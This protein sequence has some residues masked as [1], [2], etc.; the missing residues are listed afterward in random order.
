MPSTRL[1][2]FLWSSGL[3]SN[4]SNPL[5]PPSMK[6]QITDFARGAKCSRASSRLP[7]ASVPRPA[8]ALERKSRLVHIGKL[9]QGEKDVTEVDQGKRRGRL[10]LPGRRRAPQRDREG[11]PGGLRAQGEGPRAVADE[12]I[13]QER[14][15]LGGDGG[16]GASAAAGARRGRV[17]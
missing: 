9:V 10:E 5:G 7:R 8:P 2:A 3:G 14:E 4:R 13:V 11:V 16:P 6:S 12:G 17:V 15:R 1:P